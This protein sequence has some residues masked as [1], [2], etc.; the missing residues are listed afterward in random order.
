MTD[1]PIDRS[2]DR[3]DRRE[4]TISIT[5]IMAAIVTPKDRMTNA[6]EMVKNPISLMLDE[7]HIIFL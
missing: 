6:D 4:F 7:H 3:T 2:K 5:I 1:Q